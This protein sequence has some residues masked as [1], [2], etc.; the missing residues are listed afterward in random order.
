MKLPEK[1]TE[2][3]A[4][5]LQKLEARV[6][7]HKAA[8]FG[9]FC[10]FL[11]LDKTLSEDPTGGA[12]VGPAESLAKVLKL[13]EV[14]L[15]LENPAAAPLAAFGI[16]KDKSEITVLVYNRHKVE[17]RF[18]FTAEKPLTEAGVEEILAAADKMLPPPKK[19]K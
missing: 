18:T 7:E 5:L 3:F 2:P 14:V 17:R 13:K 16:D 19:A 15:G 6:V 1:P 8:H 9:E 12:A 4:V 10:I 11:T